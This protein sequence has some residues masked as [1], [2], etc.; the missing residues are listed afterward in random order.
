MVNIK[1]VRYDRDS[2]VEKVAELLMRHH[3]DHEFLIQTLVEAE[4]DHYDIFLKPNFEI[5]ELTEQLMLNAGFVVNK[6][7]H[8]AYF[9]TPLRTTSF[10]A[11]QQTVKTYYKRVRK[12]ETGIT[13]TEPRR[14][15]YRDFLEAVK[16]LLIRH[17]PEQATMLNALVEFDVR[18]HDIFIDEYGDITNL[19]KTL[20]ENIGFSVNREQDDRNLYRIRKINV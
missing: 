1:T 4:R 12:R 2:F 5:T 16:G 7:Y 14:Y 3:P 9:I 19:T 8:D 11:L 20:M 15:Y 18:H 10:Q 13:Y 6:D 17:A